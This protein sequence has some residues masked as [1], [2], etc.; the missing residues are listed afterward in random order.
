MNKKL[1]A[2]IFMIIALV[3]NGVIAILLLVGGVM[4]VHL[5]LGKSPEPFVSMIMYTL[6]AAVVF[7][8]TFLIYNGVL[9]FLLKKTKLESLLPEL[10]KKPRR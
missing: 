3:F 6:L 4:L 9:A 10:K 5:I 8:G 2:A 7:G 1:N